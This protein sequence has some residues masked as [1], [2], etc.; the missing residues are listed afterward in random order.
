MVFCS[1]CGFENND[2]KDN[3]EKCGE[4]LIKSEYLDI[5]DFENFEDI[6]TT[7][8]YYRLEDLTIEDYNTIIKNIEEMGH[9]HLK[10]Y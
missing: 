7:N 3:C 9:Y 4:L 8:H 2:T 10:E 1:K 5:K 6:F